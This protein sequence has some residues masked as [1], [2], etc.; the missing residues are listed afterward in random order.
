MIT[1][2]ELLN[3]ITRFLKFCAVITFQICC[4]YDILHIQ[5]SYNVSTLF[6]AVLIMHSQRTYSYG[7]IVCNVCRIVSPS[8]ES[9]SLTSLWAVKINVTDHPWLTRKI[10]RC[11]NRLKVHSTHSIDEKRRL[12]AAAWLVHR[13][14]HNYAGHIISP[15]THHKNFINADNVSNPLQL[16]TLLKIVIIH[17]SHGILT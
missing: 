14:N 17:F 2:L 13:L 8:S 12:I 3:A 7:W 6:S 4:S 11:K 9:W 15:V 10:S 1:M 5:Y 16:Q